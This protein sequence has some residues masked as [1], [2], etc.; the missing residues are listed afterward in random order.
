MILER[1][2][3]FVN[4]GMARVGVGGDGME[5]WLWGMMGVTCDSMPRPWARPSPG[6]RCGALRFAP[7]SPIG[8]GDDGCVG[9]QSLGCGFRR[10]DDERCALPHQ[11]GPWQASSQP[12]RKLR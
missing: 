10:K 12:G 1:V 6:R 5:S 7:R 3:W 4:G 2:F 8:V 9:T 11:G